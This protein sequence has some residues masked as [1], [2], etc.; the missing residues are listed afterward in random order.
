M[1]T[2]EAVQAVL[3]ELPQADYSEP[4]T[5]IML[6]ARTEQGLVEAVR[7]WVESRKDTHRCPVSQTVSTWQ[8]EYYGLADDLRGTGR[9][10]IW[11]VAFPVTPIS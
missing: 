2:I 11:F 6:S 5:N 7:L 10:G 1:T 4:A 8:A 9:P 3:S